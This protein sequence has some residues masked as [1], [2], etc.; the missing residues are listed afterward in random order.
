M[1]KENRLF[2]GQSN[3]LHQNGLRK[4]KCTFK[5]KIVFVFVSLSSALR[6]KNL[7]RPFNKLFKILFIS[8]P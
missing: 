1:H 7:D 8:T 6:V 5:V 2:I 3:T 4:A